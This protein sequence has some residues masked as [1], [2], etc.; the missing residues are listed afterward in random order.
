MTT[1]GAAAPRPERPRDAAGRPLPWGSPTQIPVEDYAA[2]SLEEIF[3]LGVRHFNA[4]RFFSAHEAWEEA[5]RRASGAAEEAFFRG[6]AQLGAGYTHY[7]RGNAHGARVLIERALTGIRTMG[8]AHRGMDLAGLALVLERHAALFGAAERSKSPPP[9][10][11]APL[12]AI[13]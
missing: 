3:R 9:P 1:A 8:A 11:D 7:Q 6:L 12:I 4:G 5:W 2:L 10:V 13:G